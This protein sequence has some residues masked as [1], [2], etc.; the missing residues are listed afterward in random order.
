ML[1][2][3]EHLSTAN[4]ATFEEICESDDLRE[5]VLQEVCV[6]TCVPVV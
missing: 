3:S 5:F 4:P 2:R 1:T 6:C